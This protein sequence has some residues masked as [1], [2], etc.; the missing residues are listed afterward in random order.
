MMNGENN[1]A[2]RWTT[3]RRG[4]DA[5]LELRWREEVWAFGS[6]GGEWTMMSVDDARFKNSTIK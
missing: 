4:V 2:E 5:T 1:N 6:G 3:T